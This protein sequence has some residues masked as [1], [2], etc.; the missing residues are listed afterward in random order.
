MVRSTGKTDPIPVAVG[1]RRVSRLFSA[2]RPPNVPCFYR[3]AVLA[4]ATMR[5]ATSAT[6]VSG[7]PYG[8]KGTS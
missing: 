5:V 7:E 8:V 6:F 2:G 3:S 4:I 1:E